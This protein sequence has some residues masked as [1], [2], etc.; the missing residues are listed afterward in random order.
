M[1]TLF[2]TITLFLCCNII[3]AQ[4]TLGIEFQA[5]PTGI[6]PGISFS[7]Q[8]GNQGE[9][10]IRLAANIID[11]K[12]FGVQDSEI[13]SGFGGGFGYRR[14]L[15]FKNELFYSIARSTPKPNSNPGIKAVGESILHPRSKIGF[16]F[17]FHF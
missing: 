14:T 17:I 1:K 11:H 13:G 12:D 5:Y 8:L 15:P 7:Q 2:Y 6:I 3:Q 10:V 9:V 4:K 16:Y